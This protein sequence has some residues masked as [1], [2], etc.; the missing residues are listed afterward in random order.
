MPFP[1]TFSALKSAGYR[2]SNHATCR[3]C[4]REI[5]WYTTPRD[6]KMPFD[7]MDP[8]DDDSPAVPHHATCPNADDFRGG[9]R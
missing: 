1:A 9:A 5:E 3:G 6:R 7:P 4:H 8:T 2:F